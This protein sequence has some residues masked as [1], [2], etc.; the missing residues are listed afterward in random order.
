MPRPEINGFIDFGTP[1]RRSPYKRTF[2]DFAGT[3]QGMYRVVLEPKKATRTLRQNAFYFAICQRLA[4]YLTDNGSEVYTANDMHEMA[5][6]AYL[7]RD[8]IN[9]HTG[10]IVGETA[11]STTSLSPEEFSEYVDRFQADIWTEFD[12]EPMKPDEPDVEQPS[13]RRVPAGGAA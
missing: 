13:R 4:K 6:K 11:G 8:V 3:L 5:K 2:L 7:R 9:P 12:I 1:E 10:A